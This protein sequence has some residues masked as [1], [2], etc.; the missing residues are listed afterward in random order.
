MFRL[1]ITEDIFRVKYNKIQS[2][3]KAKKR[4]YVNTW[5]LKVNN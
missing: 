5:L 2:L 4:Y 1:H 3:L